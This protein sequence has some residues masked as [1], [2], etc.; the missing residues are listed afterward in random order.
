MATRCECGALMEGRECRSCDRRP[1]PHYRLVPCSDASATDPR[2]ITGWI[3]D[4]DGRCMY[5]T[6][7]EGVLACRRH[8]GDVAG[9]VAT[10]RVVPGLKSRLGT[11][12]PSDLVR[13]YDRG[14]QDG[15]RRTEGI[16]ASELAYLLG[17][18]EGPYTW[19]E[20]MASVGALL[21]GRT[22]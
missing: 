19:D 15:E 8:A 6:V 1:P 4:L 22:G 2:T 16:L 21:E 13:E 9:G 10:L 14:L 11:A 17:V 12:L 5:D 20:L 7:E 18:P 3:L